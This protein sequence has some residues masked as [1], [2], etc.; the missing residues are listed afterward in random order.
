MMLK[1]D[2]TEEAFPESDHISFS[3]KVWY[4]LHTLYLQLSNKC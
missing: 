2:D 4:I 1:Q 3:L